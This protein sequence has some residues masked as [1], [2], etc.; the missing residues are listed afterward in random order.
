[1]SRELVDDVHARV[2]ETAVGLVCGGYGPLGVVCSE[3]AA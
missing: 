3:E 2:N 1:M